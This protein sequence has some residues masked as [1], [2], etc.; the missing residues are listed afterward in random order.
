M[1]TLKKM[2]N[3]LVKIV[4]YEK[5]LILSKRRNVKL[6]EARAII[7][8]AL[9]KLGYSYPKIG[10]VMNRHHTSIMNLVEKF[11]EGCGESVKGHK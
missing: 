8:I 10:N 7:A 6:V 3:L 5:H 9:R 11:G 4:G 2:F 1:N